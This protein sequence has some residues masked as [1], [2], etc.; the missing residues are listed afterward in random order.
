VKR[1]LNDISVNR[2][3]QAI[4]TIVTTTALLLISAA[5]I[6]Y[7]HS[8]SRRDA[9]DHLAT[10]G[11]MVAG[12]SM[13]AVA[14]GDANA[15]AEVLNTLDQEPDIQLGCTYDSS[16]HLFAEYH[17]DPGNRCLE[18]V[19]STQHTSV[20]TAGAVYRQA[21]VLHD[22]PAGY[23]YLES[24]GIQMR[25]RRT[26]FAAITMV[27]LLGSLGAGSLLG[28][29][30]GRWI[31]K[32]IVDLASVMEQVSN[33]GNYSLRAPAQ[34]ADEVGKLVSGFNQ[35][36]S[37]IEN[38]QAK[39]EHQALN[40]EL[41]GLPNRRLLGDR[42]SQALA[43]AKR[44][45][46]LVAVLYLDLD[47][48]KL[49]NDT[50]GHST[51]DLLLRQVAD[52]LRRR[53]R[54]TDT[55]ARVGGDEFTAI[56][57][58]LTSPQNA[59]VLANDLL[60]QLVEPFRINGH[61]LALTAS[62]GISVYPEHGL[63]PEQLIQTAD[64]A[65]YVAKSTGKNKTTFYT[66]EAGDAVRERLELEN[67][68]RAAL[69]RG[70]LMVYY[71][72]EFETVTRR[73]LGFEALAR[74]RHPTLGMIPPLKFIPIAEE[75]GLI[76]PIGLWVMEQACREAVRWK[77]VCGRP[78]KIAVNISTVQLLRDDFVDTVTG[79]LTQTGL[80]P[81]FLQLEL[82][83]SVLMPGREEL[84]T[85]MLQLLAVGIS[86]AVDDFGTGYSSLNYVHR[87]PF[88]CIK[89]DRSFLEQIGSSGDPRP[90]M[91]S[92][93]SMAHGLKMKV[94]VEGVET[95][96]QWRLVSEM[97]CDVMQGFMFGRPTAEPDQYLSDTSDGP[98][99]APDGAIPASP[100]GSTA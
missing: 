59:G 33:S 19:A 52:R 4:I 7:D 53:M 73:L 38:T 69:E 93:V 79:V 56:A 26:R 20:T 32:P 14:F 6:A 9:L 61:D 98:G 1:R 87:L 86:M 47:G 75:T 96:E 10:I 84:T 58:D 15:A 67:Q 92:M 65:M 35:M 78:I 89:I 71:Q 83:E 51:G 62:I 41:T 8:S 99:N 91:R 46:T 12:N 76:V 3:L 50:L 43:A 18:V 40:D 80:D 77:A 44:H 72:P 17:R 30:L 64:T 23:I 82:T 66:T 13:A 74:W 97:G 16:T 70:E 60:A 5:F 25:T 68:L 42:L 28:A 39:L 45:K 22:A 34:G 85:K 37:E 11:R 81:H 49:V 21:I 48:F 95:P 100:Q 27:F 54:A 29:A 24:D 88:D 36:L 57:T 94:I 55:L 63:E 90:M 31:A 2:K